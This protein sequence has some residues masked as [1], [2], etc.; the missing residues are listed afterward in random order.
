VAVDAFSRT[1]EGEGPLSSL[2]YEL[3]RLAA[4]AQTRAAADRVAQRDAA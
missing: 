3:R 1:P 2:T 4:E